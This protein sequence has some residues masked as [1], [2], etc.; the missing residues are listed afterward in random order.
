MNSKDSKLKIF[1]DNVKFPA[2][3][4]LISFVIGAI[5]IVISGNSPLVAYGALFSGSFGSIPVFGETL[6]KTTPLIFTGLAIAF[7][8]RCGLFNIGAEGQYIAGAISTVAVAFV[9]QNLP[10]FLLVPLIFLAGALGGALWASIVGFLKSKL[11]IHEVI[12][13]IMLNYTAMFVGNY[14]IRTILNPSTLEGSAQK[15][16]TVLLPQAARLTKFK[17]LFPSIFGHSSVNTSL[18][19]A[20]LCAFVAYFILFKTTLGYEI[21]S[22]GQ[23]PFAAEY[24]GISITKNLIISMLISGAFAGLAG[25]AQV[26]GL[27]Y[28]VDMAPALPGYG[29]TGIAVALVGKNH[30]IGVLVSALLFGILSNGERRMQIAG[31]PKEI[32]G[33]IQG[34]II[35]FIAG[36]QI[37]KI[38][39][40]HREKKNKTEEV[41]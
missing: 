31:I 7:A 23:S 17:D 41:A 3:A 40:K 9:F 35:I 28:K 29:F 12:T 27:T 5:F 4:V 38:I 24:G 19:V 33:I 22:V 8:F 1:F 32:V 13:S 2:F 21:R 10:H 18:I 37:V 36:E 25:T 34:V 14:F 30:P 39:S 20:I 11:G 6:L 26:A 15:A 16:H